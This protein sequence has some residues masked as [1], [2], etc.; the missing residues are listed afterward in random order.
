MTL[1]TTMTVSSLVNRPAR[2]ASRRFPR[3][4]R[5]RPCDDRRSG[6]AGYRRRSA[7]AVPCA[8]RRRVN[9]D[10]S[11]PPCRSTAGVRKRS[12]PKTPTIAGPAV[13][14]AAFDGQIVRMAG[15]EHG[16][17]HV[18]IKSFAEIMPAPFPRERTALP[19]TAARRSARRHPGCWAGATYCTCDSTSGLA[20]ATA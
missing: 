5:R 20:L 12:N 16:K 4:R 11:F 14:V 9:T 13:D 18:L 17:T 8:S 15:R 1:T 19:A 7:P 10:S 3:G 6:R 2:R